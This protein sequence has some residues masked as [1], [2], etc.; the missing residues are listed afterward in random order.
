MS[1]RKYQTAL[2]TT[3]SPRS[4]EYRL[5]AQVTRALME[6]KDKTVRQRIEALDMNRRM[7]LVLQADLVDGR[8]QLPNQLKAS[9][10]SLSIWVERQTSKALASGAGI[11]A[12]IDVNRAVMEGLSVSAG[13][14]AQITAIRSAA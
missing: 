11:D 5:F 2:R 14:A 10:I 7:W 1:L 4:M 8:N 9:L 13:A 12:L 6:C 3:E